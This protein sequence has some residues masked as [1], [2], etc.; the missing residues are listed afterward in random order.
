MRA[1][2]PDAT[3]LR[4]AAPSTLVLLVGAVAAV[5]A[6]PLCA[7][8]VMLITLGFAAYIMP[9]TTALMWAT[10]LLI[11]IS[12]MAVIIA[13]GMHFLYDDADRIRWQV[14]RALCCPVY[15]N[16]LHLKDGE[17]LPVVTCKL[18]GPGK[19]RLKVAPGGTDF[20]SITKLSPN[21]SASLRGRYRDYAVTLA[22][23]DV[24]YGYVTFTLE[25]VQIS[26]A[27]HVKEISMLQPGGATLLAV[28]QGTYIDLT[29]SGSMLFA[30]KTRS[31][32]TT[33][34]ISLLLQ[35]LMA[36]RDN[37]GSV[38][39]AIDPKQAEMS[40]LPHVVT[41]DK[42]GGATAILDALRRFIEIATV[43]QQ[44]LNDLSEQSGDA[45]HWWEAGMHPS[46]LFIDEYVACRTMFPAK[47][48]KGNED[49]CLATFDAL[50]KRIVTMGASAGCY[51]IISIAEA[52]VQDG[53]LPS[54]LRSAMSTK[55]LMRP[56]MPEARLLWSPE[57]LEALA[58]SA[59][60][61]G[62]G[63]AW[64]S[65]TDGEHDN[66]SYV[67]FPQ[68]EFPAYRELGRLLQEYY[69]D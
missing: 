36:G 64:F 59:R 18:I 47:P 5:A 27:V 57:Q 60:V 2:R 29:T 15:G 32:K 16:P 9:L 53:G 11:I 4:Y 13:G 61:Y 39:I 45:V 6:A 1:Y 51:V 50:V 46:I 3:R 20:E 69:G 30:G 43:R 7:L 33:A 41:L 31:G 38:V 24:S 67:H 54:M 8:I 52:S 55:V 66:V 21:I 22:N 62:P 28:Q 63:D 58:T 35:V 26:R 10:A 49:Y 25:D 48:P 68:M 34:I 42:D 12:I 19:Y 37:Y 56:T 23:S 65:S 14:L 17:R 40:N 44:A